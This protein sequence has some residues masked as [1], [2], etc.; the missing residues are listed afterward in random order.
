[1][2]TF[3]LR[4]VTTNFMRIDNAIVFLS[5]KRILKKK[6]ILLKVTCNSWT[7][8]RNFAWIKQQTTNVFKIKSTNRILSFI[9]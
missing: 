9:E 4:E 7:L 5:F 1:M 6:K 3:D 8:I 2:S